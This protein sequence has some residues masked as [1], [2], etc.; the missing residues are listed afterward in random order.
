[1]EE[2]LPI[3][4]DLAQQISPTDNNIPVHT[5]VATAYDP[6]VAYQVFLNTAWIPPGIILQIFEQPV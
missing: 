4:H 3:M 2:H 5:T 6:H 1:M